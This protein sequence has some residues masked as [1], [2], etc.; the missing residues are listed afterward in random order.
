MLPTSDIAVLFDRNHL[1][2]KLMSRINGMIINI[3]GN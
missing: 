2:K 3:H 1:E